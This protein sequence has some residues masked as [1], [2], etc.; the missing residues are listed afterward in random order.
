MQLH[1][2]VYF[3]K[4]A[5][6]GSINKAAEELFLSQPNLS[7]S[8]KSLEQEIGVPLFIRNNKG[9]TLTEDGKKLY[10]YASVI[11]QQMEIIERMSLKE[12][13]KALSVSAYPILLNTVAASRFY[14]AHKE[15]PLRLTECRVEQVI[16][17]VEEGNA[18]VGI[19][20][21]NARQKREFLT[22]LSHK[23]LEINIIAK[24]T[25]HASIG[26]KN[27]LYHEDLVTMGQLRDFPLACIPNDY[28]TNLSMHIQVDGVFMRDLRFIHFSSHGAIIEFIRNT[29]AFRFSPSR[30]Y[31]ELEE[32]GIRTVPIK[33]M[34]LCVYC[35]WIKRKRET[36]FPAAESF[37][38]IL[39]E[40]Y[41]KDNPLKRFKK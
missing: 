7:Q 32:K 38:Q 26:K 21:F 8:I 24:D 6:K 16:C 11:I 10:E 19:I 40:C 33:N 25:W 39:Q 34:D 13:Q 18:E 30:S 3:I 2:L 12:Q 29:D 41:D 9:T 36:L 37:I 14:S 22:A 15:I 17:D 5:E 20:H 1:Q 23:N 28:Y 27:P 35:G 4:V 31:Y